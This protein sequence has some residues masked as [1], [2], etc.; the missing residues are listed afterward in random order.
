MKKT[1]TLI[2]FTFL[3]CLAKGQFV[4]QLV[5]ETNMRQIFYLGEFGF[6]N[7]TSW[8]YADE[9]Y[10]HRN[11]YPGS[12]ETGWVGRHFENREKYNT[13]S[14]YQPFTSYFYD[15]TK[16]TFYKN[17]K[18]GNWFKLSTY[19]QQ[20]FNVGYTN[21][22]SCNFVITNEQYPNG[23]YF[24]PLN[25]GT[26]T[27]PAQKI[28]KAKSIKFEG[29]HQTVRVNTSGPHYKYRNM[30][31]PVI[32]PYDGIFYY[33]GEQVD[34]DPDIPGHPFDQISYF[35]YYDTNV[36]PTIV[37]EGGRG[38]PN[39]GKISFIDNVPNINI[40]PP[41]PSKWIT[42]R[43]QKEEIYQP[44]EANDVHYTFENFFVCGANTK[45]HL[46]RDVNVLTTNNLLNNGRA[47]RLV[48]PNGWTTFIN[49]FDRVVP[50][51][52]YFNEFEPYDRGT[53]SVSRYP[54]VSPDNIT[55][56]QRSSFCIDN[57]YETVSK[58]KILW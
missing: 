29:D 51:Y 44:F 55:L 38:D 26:V 34:Y 33:P 8:Y 47:V 25:T 56:P 40:A 4:G 54:W 43:N 10:E 23:T 45:V 53:N 58:L 9:H 16:P 39:A 3:F 30:G 6:R 11:G 50:E 49:S 2:L 5:H 22:L 28:G 52:A 46:G 41:A 48:R 20:D 15:Y 1:I 19:H 31:G 32:S 17:K 24:P 7:Q 14:I 12:P 35:N 36:L 18:G 37:F 57:E 21:N 13:T 27:V 42:N